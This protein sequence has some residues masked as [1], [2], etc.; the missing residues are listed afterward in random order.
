MNAYAELKE[1][2]QK[3]VN[4]F[5]LGFAFSN[6]QFKNM[7]GK[8]GLTE[9]DTDK[10]YS[11]GSGGFV[12]KCDADAM[13]EMF[14]RHAKEHTDAIKADTTGEGYIYQ[15]FAYELSNHEYDYTGELQDTLDAL[16]IT[17]EDLEKNEALRNGL[18]KALRGYRDE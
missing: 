2:Q 17:D 16:N 15:M 10:I 4:A 9:D 5:P 14:E 7:M 18:K 8:W 6:Q 1:R 3:E 12:R 13:H 11:I